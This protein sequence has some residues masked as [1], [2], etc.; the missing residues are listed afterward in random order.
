[1]NSPPFSVYHIG[2][3]INTTSKKWSAYEYTLFFSEWFISFFFVTTDH[4][5]SNDWNSTHLIATYILQ[6][7]ITLNNKFMQMQPVHS[8]FDALRRCRGIFRKFKTSRTELNVD[9]FRKIFK[10]FVELFEILEGLKVLKGGWR[11]WKFV[12]CREGFEDHVGLYSR[13]IIEPRHYWCLLH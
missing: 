2:H 9:L 7:M 1:M 4:R 13:K 11:W 12:N 6:K 3:N 8:I 5:W 10:H